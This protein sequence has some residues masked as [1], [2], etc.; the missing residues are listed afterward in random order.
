ME[1]LP[2]SPWLQLTLAVINILL[3]ILG[4]VLMFLL[5]SALNKLEEHDTRINVIDSRQ[6]KTDLVYDTLFK[7]EERVSAGFTETQKSIL[8]IYRTI[9]KRRDD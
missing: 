8:D 7:L 2:I 3:L 1:T 4:S 9:P 6:A 5:K